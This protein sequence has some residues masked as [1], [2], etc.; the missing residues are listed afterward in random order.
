MF[1]KNN[2]KGT[3]FEEADRTRLR[4]T[5][6]EWYRNWRFR[7][8]FNLLWKDDDYIPHDEHFSA[9]I[10]YADEEDQTTEVHV[11]RKD[12]NG[13]ILE[14]YTEKHF[15]KGIRNNREKEE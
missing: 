15:Y 2:W 14:E 10:P 1:H 3:P 5:E 8:G 11:V 12:K 7:N 13:K 6:K 9:H 4:G